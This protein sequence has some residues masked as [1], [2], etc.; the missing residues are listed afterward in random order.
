[1]SSFQDSV[2]SFF[3]EESAEHLA[4][5]EE[6]LLYLEN[7]PCSSPDLLNRLFRAAH[8]LKGS[9]NLVKLNP[10]G[11]IA[12]AMEDVLEAANNGHLTLG[13]FH[14][15][16]MLFSLDQIRELIRLKSHDEVI[17]PA[18]EEQSLRRLKEVVSLNKREEEEVLTSLV[19]DDPS[20]DAPHEGEKAQG[21]YYRDSSTAVR[22]KIENIESLMGMIGEFTI[23]KN[24]IQNRSVSIEKMRKEV[25]FSSKRLLD[26]V[27]G[28]AERHDYTFPTHLIPAKRNELDGFQELE[29]D[30][31]DDLN[32]FSR[33]LREISN[34][35]AEALR[36]TREYFLQLNSDVLAMD[37]TARQMK[38][39]ISE[40]RTVSAT[41]LFQRFRRTISGLAKE[42]DKPVELNVSGGQTPLDRIV[43]DGLFDPLLHIVRNALAHGIE[44]QEVRKD[45]GKPAVATIWLSAKRLGNTVEISVRDDGQ[46]ICLDKVRK[47]SRELGLINE[48][49]ELADNELIQM[50]F[51]SGFSTTNDVDATSG[52]GVGMSVVM[53][54]LSA[55]NGT[56][57]VE[58]VLGQGTVFRL[59]LPLSLVIVNVI[60]FEVGGQS[61]VIPSALVDEIVDLNYESERKEGSPLI[62]GVERLKLSQLFRLP[63]G[64]IEPR[65]AVHTRSEGKPLLLLVDA[66]SGQED[67]VI[68][69][70]GSFVQQTPYFSG[71]SIAGDGAMSLVVNP[72]RMQFAD[73]VQSESDNIVMVR[74]A[75]TAAPTVLVVDD[76]LSVRKYAGFLLEANGFKV[77]TA[78]DGMEALDILERE[79][80]DSI[81][82]DLEMPV[83]HG[84]N[85]L[86]ELQR[87]D[88]VDIPVAVLSSRAGEQHQ[89]KA[90]GL[91]ATDYLIKPFED[92]ALLSVIRKH[93]DF[94]KKTAGEL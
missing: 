37:K 85:F 18:I 69:P 88:E 92:E 61:F 19:A 59:R 23:L 78:A 35:I 80:V 51:R 42:L 73:K 39:K 17:S 62:T 83:M 55:L 68:K 33:K 76:S 24:R 75:D 74:S 12:H 58:T 11:S 27:D 65:F 54:R 3:L 9:A 77:L 93:I 8:T 15:D 70:F 29:F 53:D 63:E 7:N 14:I 72:A 60:K 46:G 6:G 41:E 81:I 34:D 21:H 90:I 1:M 26:E 32:L 44:S 4:E 71:S 30:Q 86:A 91:G 94:S 13:Q 10:V 84:Y 50:I 38:E 67:T 31:Y 79:Q 56:I 22:V 57:D 2:F 87:R 47:R 28:F 82:T 36:D 66:L 89:S 49:Q 64:N 20:V 5:L 16:A 52:R 43:Y 48:G 45:H 25:G 40:A